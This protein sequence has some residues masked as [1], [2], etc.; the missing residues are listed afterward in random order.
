MIKKLKELYN[1][2]YDTEIKDIKINSKE[3]KPGDI[4]VCT[5]GVTADRHDFIDDAI[6]NGANA[7]VVSKDV[8]V[9]IPTIKVDNTN[10]E[11]PKLSARFY[12]HP[13]R[14]LKLIG[15]TGTDGKTTTATIIQHLIGNDKCGY[16]GTNGV[17]SL[18]YNEETPNTTPDAQ[19][20]YKYL[21]NFE[22]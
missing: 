11:L 16:I 22:Q 15:I 9:N 10:E 6:K 5:K 7:L 19:L 8:K 20:L 21:Y 13:E 3:V 17:K 12:N 4:F 14:N 2:E 1:C 18:K